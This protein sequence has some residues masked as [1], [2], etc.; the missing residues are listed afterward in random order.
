VAVVE[1]FTSVW[2]VSQTNE[3]I[4]PSLGNDL[5]LLDL[6]SKL[7]ALVNQLY[8]GVTTRVTAISVSG[9]VAAISYVFLRED[10]LIFTPFTATLTKVGDRWQVD[11]DSV[12]QLATKAAV[13]TC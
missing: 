4:A 12:C 9:G 1:A 3:Q 10:E 6:R 11:R 13:S 7:V 5:G 8:P 2:D